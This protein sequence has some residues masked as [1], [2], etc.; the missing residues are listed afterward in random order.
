MLWHYLWREI[1]DYKLEDM[2]LYKN[3]ATSHTH[4]ANLALLQDKF[5]GCVI[6]GPQSPVVQ[7]IERWPHSPVSV[8]LYAAAGV[9][10]L[11]FADYN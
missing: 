8:G 3:G 5:P 9:F 7:E 4:L 10:L 2:R 6:S 1:E 11:Q